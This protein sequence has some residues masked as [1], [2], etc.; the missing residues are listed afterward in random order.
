MSASLQKGI[1]ALKEVIDAPV[2]S[3][4]ASCVHCGLCA[5]ACLFYT[6]TGDPKYTPIH[7]LE[8]LKRVYQQEYT[9]LGRLAK[10]TGLAKPVTDDELEAWSELVYDSCTMCGRCS[11]VCPVGNDLTYMIRKLREGMAVSGH[12]P[13][14]I[15]NATKRTVELGG[16]MGL[17]WPAVQNVIKHVEADSGHKVPVDQAGAEYMVLLSSMEIVNYPEYIGALARIFNKAGITWTLSSEAFEAT[18]AG[19]QIGNSDLAREIVSRIVNA[20]EKLGVKKVLSPE[21]GHAYMAIRWEGPNLVGRPFKFEV[22]HVLELLDEL[23]AKGVLKMKDKLKTPV[24]LHDPCQI[25]RRGGVLNAPEALLKE[26]VVEFRPMTD[27]GKMN[28]CCGGGGGASAIHEPA[29]E[30]LRFTAFKRKKAQIEETGVNTMVT[31][32]ANCRIT[33]EESIDHF[34]MNTQL[35]GLTELLAEHLED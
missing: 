2:A 27:H 30:E 33:L 10:M 22:V 34:E 9:L 1:N 29:A 28:W 13:E 26:V 31:F 11:M 17:K 4:F 16:P 7:K 8:P 24:T 32:C 23:R 6:E 3:F 5:E 12:A 35:L 21:C 19:I 14:G 20:A 25:V 15:V 18:N